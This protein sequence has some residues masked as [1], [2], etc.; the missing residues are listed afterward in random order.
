MEISLVA[1]ARD[2]MRDYVPASTS[3]L[4]ERDA[5]LARDSLIDACFAGCQL[6]SQPSHRRSHV[7]VML[8]HAAC[9]YLSHRLHLSRCHPLKT[10]LAMVAF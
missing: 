2:V 1:S 8:C 5:A 6:C 3:R 9:G 10:S 4:V 7:G